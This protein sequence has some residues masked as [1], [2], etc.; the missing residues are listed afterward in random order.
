M[1][2][3]NLNIK[4]I[5][6]LVL[7]SSFFSFLIILLFHNEHLL[8]LV[9]PFSFGI[10]NVLFF[11]IFNK[12]RSSLVAQIIVAG[13]TIKMCIIPALFVLSNF[14]IIILS[15]DILK[16]LPFA[17]FLSVYEVL[18]IYLY[19]YYYLFYRYPKVINSKNNKYSNLQDYYY[20][21]NINYLILFSLIF[22]VL[23]ILARY[24]VLINYFKFFWETDVNEIIKTNK[25][26]SNMKSQVPSF[27]YWLYTY[28]VELLRVFIIGFIVNVYYRKTNIIRF[29]QAIILILLLISYSTSENAVVWIGVVSVVI[30]ILSKNKE[31]QKYLLSVGIIFFLILIFGLIVKNGVLFN[32]IFGLLSKMLSAYFPNV[33]HMTYVFEM[34]TNP[35]Y[36]IKDILSSLP[37]I[38]FYFKGLNTGLKEYNNVVMS[39]GY[40]GNDQIIPSIAQGVYY[41]SWVLSPF[42]I[43]ISLKISTFFEVK[44]LKSKNFIS[45][46][47]YIFIT[48]ISVLSIITFNFT[49]LIYLLAYY[50]PLGL[51]IIFNKKN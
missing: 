8:I 5:F 31:K 9:L 2:F 22:I 14:Q 33:I 6:I 38:K 35:I 24:N 45:K 44:V 13:Y 15:G 23:M 46:Y 27:F 29:F 20:I 41:F 3:E 51:L 50:S 49:A 28:I 30:L 25:E 4:K 12:I 37:F 10:I 39:Y 47:I 18:F 36:L 19:L 34:D 16:N 48:I 26:F 32:D 1:I 21:S 11:M 17:I 40:K 42:L 43:I 7:F